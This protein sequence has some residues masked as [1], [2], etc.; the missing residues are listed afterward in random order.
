MNGPCKNEVPKFFVISL[1]SYD[2]IL[3]LSRVRLKSGTAPDSLVTASVGEGVELAKTQLRNQK[4]RVYEY[5]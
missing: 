1:R 3:T 5:V 4:F 2:S